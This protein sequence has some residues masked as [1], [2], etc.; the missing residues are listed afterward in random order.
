M[1]AIASY[2]VW[3][4]EFT[5]VNNYHPECS[6]FVPI[7]A[8]LEFR[9]KYISILAMMKLS[10]SLCTYVCKRTYACGVPRK[11]T[12][13]WR[14]N[15]RGGVWNHQ[16]HDSLLDR[17]F[18]S[19]S[20]KPSKLRVTGLCGVNSP[21]AGEYRAQRASTAENVSIWWRHHELWRLLS[22]QQNS[23]NERSM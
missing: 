23:T 6:L 17:L 11:C 12:L 16:P 9:D 19:R 18:R 5:T 7:P 21:L 13:Q 2:R 15:G 20:T 8:Y 3:R 10:H 4:L 1:V 14:Y 22:Q